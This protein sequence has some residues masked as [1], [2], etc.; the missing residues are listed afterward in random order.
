[1]FEKRRAILI[2]DRIEELPNLPQEFIKV[3]LGCA[4]P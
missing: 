4:I 3:S 2:Y 1:M